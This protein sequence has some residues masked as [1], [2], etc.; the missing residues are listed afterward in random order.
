MK[1]V[2]KQIIKKLGYDI[3]RTNKVHTNE[4][5]RGIDVASDIS[6]YSETSIKTIFDVGANVG[7]TA[8]YFYNKFPEAKIFSFEPIKSTFNTLVENTSAIRNISCFNHAFGAYEGKTKVY[9]QKY[10]G[11][12]SLV[13]SKNIDYNIGS[14]VVEI[15][16]INQFAKLHKIDRIDLLKTDTEGYDLEVLK[17]AEDFLNGNKVQFILCEV[18]FH[19]HDY[20]HTYFVEIH[21]YLNSKGFQIF[22]IYDTDQLYYIPH[23]KYSRFSFCNALFINTQIVIS[24]KAPGYQNFLRAWNFE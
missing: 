12:N 14:E 5:H 13:E 16:T 4:L 22:D 17:G 6:Q 8:Q 2:I 9:L 23:H 1:K 15:N 21:D 19:K 11:W 3:S 7:Q 18:G 24:Q 20:G 10:S